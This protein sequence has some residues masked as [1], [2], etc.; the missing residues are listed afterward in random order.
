VLFGLPLCHN[1]KKQRINPS[2]VVSKS[3]GVFAQVANFIAS[4]PSHIK[5]PR[6]D[7]ISVI[8]SAGTTCGLSDVNHYFIE[9]GY[10][11]GFIGIEW[12]VDFNLETRPTGYATE[13]LYVTLLLTQSV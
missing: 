7:P 9:C 4:L 10:A 12:D 1:R 5:W 8:S 11:N 13:P 6:K 2:L 3:L